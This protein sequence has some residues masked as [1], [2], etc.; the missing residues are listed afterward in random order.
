MVAIRLL[1]KALVI[2]AS[3]GSLIAAPTAT[4][5][6]AA[7][8]AGRV[9][10]P[11]GRKLYLECQ[12]HGSPTVILEAGLRNRADIWSEPATP[13]QKQATVFP[14]VASFTRVCSYDR[15]GTTLGADHRSRSDPVRMPR[16]ASEAVA[17]LHALI[18]T[19]RIPG[20]YIL[21]GHSTGGLLVRLYTSMYPRE[22]RGVV[23]VDA[24]PETMETSL[25][26]T[27]WNG[28]NAAYLTAAPPQL[29]GYA[30]LETFDFRRSFAEMR[31]APTPARQIPLI[32]LS[33]GQPFGIP[34]PLGPAVERA[35]NRGQRYLASLEP[36]T[37][38]LVVARSGHYIQ[39]YYPGLVIDAVRRVL[40]AARAGR[41]TA[42]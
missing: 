42:R 23:L 15:P 25:T 26:V 18:K 22:V 17:D 21:V 14:G 5:T 31:K 32:V 33:K 38:H 12:G 24:I 2:A 4:G 11:S 30:D 6:D 35:W 1:L 37:P 13:T 7:S 3:L 16:T 9:A 27:Q 10:L 41:R 39:V 40:A 8:F 36:R 34:A 20:P 19:A 29:A 28:Y